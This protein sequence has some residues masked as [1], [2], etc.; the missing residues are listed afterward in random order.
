MAD[1]FERLIFRIT[2]L[3]R[4]VRNQLR[5]G[6]VAE[7]DYQNARVKVIDEDGDQHKLTTAWLPWAEVGGQIKSWNPPVKDQQVIVVSPSGEVGQGVVLPAA[8]SDHHPQPSTSGSEQ[9]VTFG[10]TTVRLTEG[11]ARIISPKIVLEG[12]VHLGGDSGKLVHRKGDLDSD[13]DAAVGSASKVYA[14]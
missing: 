9:L 2:E 11:E 6:R 7:V 3:E 5:T 10:E 1:D 8:F 4:R 13:G 12:D 14:V